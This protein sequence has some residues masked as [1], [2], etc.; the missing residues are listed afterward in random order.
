MR[1][2]FNARATDYTNQQVTTAWK[3]VRLRARTIISLF[4]DSMRQSR[5]LRTRHSTH[6]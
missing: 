2:N 1:S 3:T 6:D 4:A 5:A